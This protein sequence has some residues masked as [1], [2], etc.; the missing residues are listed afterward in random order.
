MNTLGKS[1]DY[2]EG[3][4]TSPEALIEDNRKGNM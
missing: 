3:E 1:K 2:E 4:L